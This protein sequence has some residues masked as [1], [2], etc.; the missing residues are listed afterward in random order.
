[1]KPKG[2]TTIGVRFSGAS[3]VYTYKVRRG[4]GIKR[5]DMCAVESPLDGPALVFVVRVDKDPVIP[6]GFSM[7]TLKKIIGVV[8]PA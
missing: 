8:K 7:K 3:R 2:C 1:M 5:G 6:L 4:H